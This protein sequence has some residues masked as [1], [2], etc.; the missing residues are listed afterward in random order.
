MPANGT[1]VNGGTYSK[2]YLNQAQ[3]YLDKCTNANKNMVIMEG[4]HGFVLNGAE[5]VAT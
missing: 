2:M 3:K 4:D 1:V 5:K